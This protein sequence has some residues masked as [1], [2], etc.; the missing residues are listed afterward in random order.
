[1]RNPTF[2]VKG[3]NF[4]LF[5]RSFTL[6][7]LQVTEEKDIYTYTCL[8]IMFWSRCNTLSAGVNGQNQSDGGMG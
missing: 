5:I 7:A 2:Q 3:K 8:Y 6:A 4:S 1:M